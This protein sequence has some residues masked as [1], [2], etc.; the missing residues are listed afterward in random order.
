MSSASKTFISAVAVCLAVFML[1]VM[2]NPS[3]PAWWLFMLLAVAWNISPLIAARIQ[4]DRE[5]RPPFPLF[6]LLFGLIYVFLG[7]LIY[8]RYL[9]PRPTEMNGFMVIFFPFAGWAGLICMQIC[10]T[11]GLLVRIFWRR[12]ERPQSR[13]CGWKLK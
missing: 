3:E 4:A 1:I 7:G 11:L 5:S 10:A 6:M 9:Y 12:D 13:P 8:Y 2:G